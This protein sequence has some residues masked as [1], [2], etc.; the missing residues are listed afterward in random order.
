MFISLYIYIYIWF[1]C[2]FS[3]NRVGFGSEFRAGFTKTLTRPGPAS[4][5]ILKTQTRPYCFT[6]WVKPIPL[7][8]GRLFFVIPIME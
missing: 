7:R 2:N 6:G 1:F 8:A 3:F 5:F 4:G